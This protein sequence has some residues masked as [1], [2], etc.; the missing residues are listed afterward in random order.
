MLAALTVAG[1]A[2]YQV[3][4]AGVERPS[5]TDT[6]AGIVV[7]VRGPDLARVDG[8]V[9]RTTDGTRLTFAVETLRLDGGGKPAPHLREHMASGEPIEVEYYRDGQRNVAVRYRDAD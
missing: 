8:F 1:L 7:E 9:L 3:W 6:A 4:Q 2:L 5:A